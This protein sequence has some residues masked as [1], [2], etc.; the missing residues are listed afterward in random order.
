MGR[1]AGSSRKRLRLSHFWWRSHVN[2]AS[3]GAS[4]GM[5]SVMLVNVFSRM[6]AAGTEGLSAARLMATAPPID[7][8][9]KT[10][11]PLPSTGWFV[12]KS[13][14]VWASVC[15]RERRQVSCTGHRG[16]AGRTLRRQLSGQEVSHLDALLARLAL[17]KTVAAV[18]E[19][20]TVHL[21]VVNKDLGDGC[22][23]AVRADQ[24]PGHVAIV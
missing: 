13:S 10:I 16:L 4:E 17:A 2:E 21:E 19:H 12:R 6:S 9:K 8:P 5:R 7:W 18:R 3:G 23:Q 14:A 15:A 20:E 24:R 11:G 22:E 1:S